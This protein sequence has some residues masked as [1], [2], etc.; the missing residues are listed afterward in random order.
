[1]GAVTACLFFA[2][3]TTPASAW[4]ELAQRNVADRTD[5]DT[6]VLPGGRMFNHIRLCVYRQ[7][8]HFIDVDVYFRNGGH[9]DVRVAERINAGRCTRAI[10]LEGGQRD[11]D[12]IALVYEETSF[13]R[14][15][16]TVL[17][18]AE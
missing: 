11:I 18:F 16:A 15:T 7:P 2:A 14:R 6:I 17:L 12:H 10:D 8:V 4:V 13:R 3:L 1:L 9:Q 5:H